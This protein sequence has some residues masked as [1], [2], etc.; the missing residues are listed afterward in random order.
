MKMPDKEMEGTLDALCNGYLKWLEE[1][2]EDPDIKP[3]DKP[4]PLTLKGHR[5]LLAKACNVIDPAGERTGNADADLPEEAFVRIQDSFKSKTGAADNCIKALKAAYRWGSKR[6]G[7]PKD[8]TVFIVEKVHTNRGGADAWKPEDM[9]KFLKR[10]G[11]GTMA[12]LWFLLSLNTL[13]RIGDV[14]RLG[15]EH[16]SAN[17]AIGFQ[18]S[19]KG[20]AFVEVPALQQLLGELALHPDRETFITTEAGKSFASSE[21]MRNRIQDWTAQAKLPKGR[22]Q[23]GIR[24]GAAEL[25][26]EAGATQYEIMALMSHTEAKTSE[27]YTKRV[28][29]AGL[30]AR[31]IERLSTLNLED[32]DHGK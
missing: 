16:L 19:K 6:P 3:K 11:S 13:P 30:A 15:P 17:K 10:H 12:R 18:P 20:S 8:S 31:A 23:H 4:S 29:R 5:S 26:A 24:K 25:L 32:V 9:R 14:Y 7:F 2:I 28:Q 21:S 27:I 22:T 1:R